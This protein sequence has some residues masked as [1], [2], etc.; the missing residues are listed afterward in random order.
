MKEIATE[1]SHSLLSLNFPLIIFVFII[2]FLIFTQLANLQL[3][4]NNQLQHFFHLILILI[5][6]MPKY[7]ALIVD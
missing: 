1:I 7:T 6:L 3:F 4:T 5:Q 2:F